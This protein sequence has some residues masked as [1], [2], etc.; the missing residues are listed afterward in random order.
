MARQINAKTYNS[1]NAMHQRCY[2][3]KHP[4]YIYYGAKGIT[5]CEEWHSYNNF[6]LDMGTRPE[7]MTIDRIDPAGNYNK[8]NCR[9]ASVSI[10]ARNKKHLKQEETFVIL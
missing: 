9:W 10:Q 7:N 8:Q 5:V 3:P 4:S 1:W 6:L 2:N